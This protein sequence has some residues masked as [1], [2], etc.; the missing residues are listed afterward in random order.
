MASCE[1]LSVDTLDVLTHRALHPTNMLT[2]GGKAIVETIRE[3]FGMVLTGG[4]V[5]ALSLH[6]FGGLTPRSIISRGVVLAFGEVGVSAPAVDGPKG[7]EI[8]GEGL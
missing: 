5:E 8:R 6:V 7:R 3:A 1:E 4:G 2:T